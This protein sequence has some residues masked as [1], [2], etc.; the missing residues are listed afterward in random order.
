MDRFQLLQV[1]L[2]PKVTIPTPMSTK[3]FQKTPEGGAGGERTPCHKLYL[4]NSKRLGAHEAWTSWLDIIISLSMNR[5]TD[6]WPG[7][8][9]CESL[10]TMTEEKMGHQAGLEGGRSSCRL[11]WAVG[12]GGGAH[13]HCTGLWA[14]GEEAQLPP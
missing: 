10:C 13:V 3:T 2:C 9:V 4:L 5:L 8:E 12:V 11:Y 1:S 7:S 14:W 6:K